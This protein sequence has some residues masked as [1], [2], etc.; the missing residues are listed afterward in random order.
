MYRTYRD[1]YLMEQKLEEAKAELAEAK[2]KCDPDNDYDLDRL[3]D[4]ENDVAYWEEQ[5][6]FAWQDNEAE[7]EGYE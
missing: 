1:P 4:L 2:A 3:I 6:N 7:V 5:V